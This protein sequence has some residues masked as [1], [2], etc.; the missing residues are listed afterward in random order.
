MVGTSL[1]GHRGCRFCCGG[2]A[3][4]RSVDTAGNQIPSDYREEL[5]NNETCLQMEWTEKKSCTP[6]S[7]SVQAEAG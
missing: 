2:F 7:R 1:P 6:I 5:Y 3:R 4:Q